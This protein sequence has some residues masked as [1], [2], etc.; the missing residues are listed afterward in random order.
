MPPSSGR[1]RHESRAAA[2]PYKNAGVAID[3]LHARL[4]RTAGKKTPQ[5]LVVDDVLAETL[6][7]AGEEFG[8][9]FE[10]PTIAAQLAGGADDAVAGDG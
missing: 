1:Y 5:V 6:A 9:L 7:F 8:L 10:A 3:E 2:I 4:L